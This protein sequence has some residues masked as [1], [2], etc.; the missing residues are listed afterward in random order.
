V[1]VTWTQACLTSLGFPVGPI[2]G[3]VGPQTIRAFQA[4]KRSRFGPL[5]RHLPPEY[6]AA[7][8]AQECLGDVAPNASR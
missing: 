1:D 2:D 7:R 4:W 6:L 5:A 8:L 3:K